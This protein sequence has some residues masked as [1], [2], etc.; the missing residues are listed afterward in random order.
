M[1]DKI[2]RRKFFNRAGLLVAGTISGKSLYAHIR[3]D[4]NNSEISANKIKH[5]NPSDHGKA[6]INPGM[7]WT[8]HFYSNLLP[9]YG[10]K[11]KAADTLDDFPGLSTIYLRIPWAYVEPEKGNFIWETLDTPAQRWIEKGKKVAFRITATENWMRQ[12]TPQWVFDAGATPLEANGYIEPDYDDP[13]FLKEVEHFVRIIA[14]RYDGNSNVAFVDI[15]HFGMWGEGH[16]VLTSP[17]HKKTW[18]LEL[19]KKMIDLY[20]RHFRNTLLCISDDYAGPDREGTRFPITDYAFSQGV[21]IRDDSILVQ[22]YPKHWFHSEMAQLFWPALPVIL[23]HEHYRN[24]KSNKAWNK[25]LLLKSVEDYHASYMSI[26][27]WP[28]ELLDEN[29][30]IINRINRRMGYRLQILHIRWPA[31]VHKNK[32]F[33]IQTEWNNAGVAPCYL[34]GYPCFTLKDEE[35]GIIAVLVDTSFNLKE[36]PPTTSGEVNSHPLTSRFIIAPTFADSFGSYS[37]TCETGSFDLYISA[38]KSDGTPMFELP[39]PESDGHKRYRVGTIEVN[40]N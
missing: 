27:G 15:G 18:G 23:E 25:E 8:M 1:A 6:L 12:A 19:Q 33:R 2:N 20:R 37:R 24:S 29:R 31:C 22:P 38:G 35:G 21:T 16:T 13:V 11:L 3:F 40:E 36:L 14:E 28:R 9:N 34:G 17:V 7:G 26:H 5:F 32:S 39:Y 30:D 4:S 10:S